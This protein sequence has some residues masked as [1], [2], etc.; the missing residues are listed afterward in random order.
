MKLNEKDGKCAECDR[1]VKANEGAV[2]QTCNEI[3]CKR[4]VNADGQ[5]LTC[6][7]AEDEEDETDEEEDD[8]GE[9]WGSSWDDDDDAGEE[10]GD[11]EG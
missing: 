4:H 6:V 10:Y 5:C 3:V 11:E 1:P 9:S 2:C 7:D 8:A